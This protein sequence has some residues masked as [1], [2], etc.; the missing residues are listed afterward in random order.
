MIYELCSAGGQ[1]FVRRTTRG[2]KGTT[3]HETDRVPAPRAVEL[4]ER[5]LTGEAR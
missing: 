5:I 1:G 2:T 4:F 3:I